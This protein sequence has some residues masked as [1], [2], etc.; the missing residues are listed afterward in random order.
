MRSTGSRLCLPTSRTS[1][2]RGTS[3][4]CRARTLAAKSSIS[5]CHRIS[6]P[7]LSSPRS[8]P[9]IPANRLPAVMPIGIPYRRTRWFRAER[10]EG[11]VLQGNGEEPT[12]PSNPRAR[13]RGQCRR[14]RR[15]ESRTWAPHASMQSLQSSIS[16]ASSAQGSSV[17]GFGA[18]VALRGSN[19]DCEACL[20]RM[21]S[22]YR[23]RNSGSGGRGAGTFCRAAPR[24]SIGRSA[25]GAVPSHCPNV[26]ANRCG[27]ANCASVAAT[28]RT[29]ARST[30]SAPCSSRRG[31]NADPARDHASS[32]P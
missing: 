24:A 20:R 17:V 27:D 12:S 2:W 13:A 21:D 4:Q 18:F 15:R 1:R 16:G 23:A 31:E 30:R 28:Y 7:A 26:L 14:C 22:S 5:H 6:K 29:H 19:R 11:Q 9:P 25:G 10:A 32:P 3:G 8:I